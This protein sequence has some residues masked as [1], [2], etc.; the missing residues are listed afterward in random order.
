MSI[1]LIKDTLISY[2]YNHLGLNRASLICGIAP[3]LIDQMSSQIEA[4]IRTM[5]VNF[6]SKQQT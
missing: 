2:L 6:I 5:F 4:P 3:K 1:S